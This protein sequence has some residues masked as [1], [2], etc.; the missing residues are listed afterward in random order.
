MVDIGEKTA[1]TD[2]ARDYGLFLPC[3]KDGVSH[4]SGDGLLADGLGGGIWLSVLI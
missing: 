4:V 2:T 1:D 3:L